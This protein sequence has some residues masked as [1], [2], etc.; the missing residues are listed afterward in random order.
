MTIRQAVT[1]GAKRLPHAQTP[2]LDAI[3]L[4][5]LAAGFSK[6]QLLASYPEQLTDDVS[7]RY[8]KL[9]DLRRKGMPVSY[10]R[11]KKEFYS[12][13]FSVGPGVLVPRPETEILV[14]V[15]IDLIGKH[16]AAWKVHDACTGSGCV[17]ISIKHELPAAD[18]SVSDISEDALI[19]FKHNSM[20]ILGEELPSTRSDLLAAVSGVFDVIVANPPYLTSERWAQMAAEGWPEPALALD[21]G[22]DGLEPYKKLIPQ[23]SAHLRPGGYLLLEA[24][25]PQFVTIQKLLVQNGFHNAIIYTDLAGRQ[26]AIRAESEN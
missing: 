25:P 23:S 9:L 24:D 2:L 15:V 17:A 3:V 26:R 7:V 13:E 21:G 18:I 1:D 6:E 22:P 10:I 20:T 19:Y 11:K 4:L 5:S 16:P 14:D 12:L 8:E